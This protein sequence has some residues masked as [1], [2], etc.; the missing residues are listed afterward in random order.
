MWNRKGDQL[1]RGPGAN[2]EK[3]ALGRL[4]CD[5]LVGIVRGA[6]LLPKIGGKKVDD[7][8]S[9]WMVTEQLILILTTT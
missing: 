3:V 1:P 7:A 2:D 9:S 4:H 6:G 8:P 5:S